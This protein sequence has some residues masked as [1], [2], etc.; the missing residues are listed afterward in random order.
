MGGVEGGWQTMQQGPPAN[1]YQTN[2]QFRPPSG[3]GQFPYQ[4][5]GFPVPFQVQ[6]RHPYPGQGQFQRAPQGFVPRQ[7][8]G[9]P[10][11][12][13]GGGGAMRGPGPGP[14]PAGNYGFQGSPPQH[15]QQPQMSPQLIRQQQQQVRIAAREQGA[16][17]LCAG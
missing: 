15:R 11:P 2:Q 14:P 3:P 12:G 4:N 16:G 8:F 10:Y 13:G 17:A 9:G 5:Q 7:Q 1:S 6:G